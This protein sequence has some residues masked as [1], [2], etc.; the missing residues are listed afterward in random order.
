[1]LCTLK[2]MHFKP[3]S[4]PDVNKKIELLPGNSWTICSPAG[5][6]GEQNK[7]SP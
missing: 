5:A 4:T 3:Q 1:M 7:P 6:C 2:P